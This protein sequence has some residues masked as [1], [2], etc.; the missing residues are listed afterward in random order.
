MGGGALHISLSSTWLLVTAC[1]LNACATRGLT[2]TSTHTRT[3]K[4]LNHPITHRETLVS[5]IS[6]SSVTNKKEPGDWQVAWQLWFIKWGLHSLFQSHLT[7]IT[8]LLSA[9]DFH[10]VSGS[11]PRLHLSLCFQ[12][13]APLYR[14][15][16][17]GAKKEQR[18]LQLIDAQVVRLWG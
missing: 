12:I 7:L 11:L 13:P 16:V 6:Q 18:H 2:H 15:K 5:N 17:W 1:G 4:P 14:D 8:F 9:Q 3:T 10:L